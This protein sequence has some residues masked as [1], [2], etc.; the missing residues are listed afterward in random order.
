METWKIKWKLSFF[1]DLLGL[2][3]QGSGACIC[4]R[5]VS[6]RKGILTEQ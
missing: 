2:A 4:R 1:C 6:R 5:G 3:V